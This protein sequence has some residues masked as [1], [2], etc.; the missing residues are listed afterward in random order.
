VIH[1]KRE[2]LLHDLIMAHM[3]AFALLEAKEQR[4]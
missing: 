1:P 3:W 2:R 4:L